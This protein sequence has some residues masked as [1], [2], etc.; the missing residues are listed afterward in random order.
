MKM[1]EDIGLVLS[2]EYIGSGSEKFPAFGP[3]VFR[4]II[5]KF[6][7]DVGFLS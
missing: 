5:W 2:W 1:Y 4:V 3:A 7:P 6:E